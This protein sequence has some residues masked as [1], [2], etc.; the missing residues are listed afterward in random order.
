MAFSP[1]DQLPLARFTPLSRE[2][3]LAP[4][5]QQRERHDKLDEAYGTITNE[6]EKAR[7]MLDANPNSVKLRDKFT[8]YVNELSLARDTLLNDGVTPSSSRS[9]L[10]LKSR[11]NSEISPVMTAAALR[12]SD[13]DA[14]NK[15]KSS[16]PTYEGINPSVRSLDDYV[17]NG[18]LPF[19]REGISGAAV[20]K[21]SAEIFRNLGKV[22][23]EHLLKQFITNPEIRPI[24]LA[25]DLNLQSPALLN[26]IT[27]AG[28]RPSDILAARE[29]PVLRGILD[30][31]AAG[32]GFDRFDP[33]ARARL[34][35][36][37]NLGMYHGL[38]EDG[39]RV[40]NNPMFGL[41]QQARARDSSLPD[42]PGPLYQPSKE[43]Q[44]Y[45]RRENESLDLHAARASKLLSDAKKRY[46]TISRSVNN[47]PQTV[48]S[49]DRDEVPGTFLKQIEKVAREE[50]KDKGLTD[51]EIEKIYVPARLAREISL[52]A[53]DVSYW[54]DHV[55]NFKG[56]AS[57]DFWAPHTH[58]SPITDA[59]IVN[60]NKMLD[61]YIIHRYGTAEEKETGKY[62]DWLKTI[63]EA[64][65]P[66]DFL[67][68]RY[69]IHSALIPFLD[70]DTPVD[71]DGVMQS[72]KDLELVN[73]YLRGDIDEMSDDDFNRVNHLLSKNPYAKDLLMNPQR[74][75][76]DNKPVTFGDL[77]GQL[78]T[79]YERDKGR[80]LD[81]VSWSN[82]DEETDRDH[83]KNLLG[84]LAVYA[85]DKLPVRAF[86][87][88]KGV[89]GSGRLTKSE[90]SDIFGDFTGKN[91]SGSQ[92]KWGISPNKG[93]VVISLVKDDK[94]KSVLL[95]ALPEAEA[96]E[97]F[98]G[99]LH[100]I[101]QLLD[102]TN[103]PEDP[104]GLPALVRDEELAKAYDVLFNLV[105]STTKPG[106]KFSGSVPS[107][108]DPYLP[109]NQ[110]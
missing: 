7:A 95:D 73:S 56:R 85:N 49:H 41:E 67:G 110:Q 66:R 91:S 31:I 11:Y 52:I 3:L 28:L 93:G 18:L 105:F 70:A 22:M 35:H 20:Y 45:R 103:I 107:K 97:K 100:Y 15:L 5:L 40:I 63:Q 72:G 69:K 19:A 62:K 77:A 53:N 74:L 44:F 36:Q 57:Y 60:D 82:A 48:Q 47:I 4:A 46:K 109:P 37:A 2:D 16:D 61:N 84:K 33:E 78:T 12:A 101:K 10:D 29:N 1:Y 79:S 81:R 98:Q 65:L 30:Q 13:V 17:D 96:N 23:P 71:A 102:P 24:F 32:W 14:F 54:K 9:L 6:I 50:L 94:T 104:T 90:I 25:N 39:S 80:F 86:D 59:I 89:T 99:I 68:T 42:D 58:L 51:E 87:L 21:Q 76:V 34:E 75:F 26:I 83:V 8:N 43:T 106:L 108:Y 55:L 92:V 38:G 64:P 88:E 27:R